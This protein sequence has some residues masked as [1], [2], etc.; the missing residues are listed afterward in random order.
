MRTMT[1]VLTIGLM[2]APTV[3]MAAEARKI[4]YVDV[5]YLIENSPQAQEASSELQKEFAP[6]KQELDK[7]KKELQKLQQKLEKEGMTLSE[8]QRN[9]LRQRAQQLQRDIKRS[10]KALQEEVNIERNDAFQGVRKAVME[11]VQA[12]AKERGYDVVVGQNALYAS[13]RVNITQQ[14]LE[15]MKSNFQGDSQ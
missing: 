15:R 12:V 2:I 8:S 3:T 6:Q 5:Q 13:E 14:V 1:L 9:E 10:Q 4:G 7:K 11:S